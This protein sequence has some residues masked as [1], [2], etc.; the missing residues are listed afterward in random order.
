MNWVK[1]RKLPA[2]EA[3]KYNGSPCLS[4][5][6]L[7][8]TL[9]NS[10]NTALHRQVDLS[11][12]NKVECKPCQIWNPFSR[13]EFKSAI[14]KCI[15]TSAPGPDKMSWRH[16]K[17]IFKN[18][19]CLSKIINITNACINLGHWP[20]Y[21]KTSST[22]IIPKPNKTLYD[23]PK[24]FHPI[25]LFNTLGKLVEKVIAERIQFIVASNNFIHSN[26]LGGL[27]FKSTSNTGIALI[28][29]IH[30]GWSKGRTTSTLAFDISQFFSFLNHRLLVLILE[31]AGLS[32]K[33]T[34]FFANY[35]VQRS[36]KYLW[37]DLS[38][39]PFEVN[40]EVSQGSAL[41]SIL[42]TLYLSPLIYIM[43]NRFKNLNL[44]IS[45]LSFIDD[46][47]LIVQ[48]KS[49]N[50]SN[51]NL[52]CSYNILSKLLNSFGLIIE[53]SKTEIF[54]FNRFHGPFNPP[55]LDLSP[56]GG[57]I[58]QPK[59][60]WRYL[61]FIFNRKLSFHKHIDHYANKALLTV[62]CMKLL[63]NSSRGI[64]PVQKH[65]LYRCCTL[66]IAL[67]GFQLWF[68]N[69]ALLLYHMKILKKMQRRA[70]IWILGGFK[71]SPTEGIEAIAGLTPIKFHLQKIAKRSLICPFKLPE[72]HIIKNLLV[73]D[74]PSTKTTNSH[75]IGFLTN[76]QRSLTKG[77]IVDS[78]TKS[79]G[80]FLS[81][82]PLDPEFS[83]GSRIINNFSNRF[84]FN[85]VNKKE[86]NQSKI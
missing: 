26:Q 15:D 25:V 49:L 22:V 78:N 33:V 47:L 76:R 81:F 82:S 31:K 61:G 24:V 6:S 60:S 12:L 62:K 70:A 53:H 27:K 35:L 8:N 67:Y 85:L 73:D 64:N 63:G 29:I 3:I 54:H 43:E 2:T 44:P 36:T 77:F 55:L 41:S 7:W 59:E 65:L 72:N 86:K 4:P 40:I 18:D 75:N 20:N 11:I 37:N 38:S 34:N 57:P 66:P 56:L 46:G 58:L 51:L 16:W 19:N 10:F 80:I 28:H 79:Y 71:T 13:Y 50:I 68:Y 21:F 30:S 45:I 5:D 74:P 52:F 84:S 14:Y 83:P 1:K 42:S 48:N 39:L 17:L 23:S 9:H 32:P 69:K